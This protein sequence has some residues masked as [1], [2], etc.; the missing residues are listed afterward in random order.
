MAMAMVGRPRAAA[1]A[2]AAMS[3]AAARGG[4]YGGGGGG[5]GGDGGGSDRGK[6]FVDGAG[7][8]ATWPT[9]CASM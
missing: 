5:S 6:L 8:K 2:A 9:F 1:A 7:E 4:V 3:I